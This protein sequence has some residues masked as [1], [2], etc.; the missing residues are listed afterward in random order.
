MQVNDHDHARLDGNAEECD[1]PNPHGNAEVVVEKPLK[2]ETPS[3]RIDRRENKHHRL[4]DRVKDHVQQHEDHEEHDGKNEFQAFFGTQLKFVF[5]GPLV[6]ISRRQP[7]FLLQQT[8][9]LLYEAAIIACIQ[10]DVDITSE[11]TIF[12]SDHRRATR[13]GK[14]RYLAN[15]D[16]CSRRSR[17]KHPAKL[18]YVV[19]EVALVSNANRIALAALDVLCY[20]HAAYARHNRFLHVRN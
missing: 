6:G 14:G 3:H 17:N 12:I 9:S 20:V 5:A 18:V 19:T 2:D 8:R 1:V 16:L 10:V 15:W 4:R 13:K 7:Q 11:L